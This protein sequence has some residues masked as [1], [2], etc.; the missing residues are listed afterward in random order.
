MTTAERSRIMRAVKGAD[1][2]IELLV[3]ALVHRMGFRYRL[4]CSDLPGKPDLV[5][6]GRRKVI[7]VNGC[8]WHGHPCARGNRVPKTNRAYWVRKIARNVDRDVRNS[9][10][11]RAD[12]WKS[13]VIWECETKDIGRVAARVKKFLGRGHKQWQRQRRRWRMP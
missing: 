3:R 13:L 5:F 6:A 1:T 2:G 12:G 10:W 11:L 7:F 4:H 8:F 9:A